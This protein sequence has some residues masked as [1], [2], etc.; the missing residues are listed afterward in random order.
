[1]MCPTHSTALSDTALLHAIS[2]QER[3]G[4]PGGGK[5]IL[6]QDEHTGALSTLNNQYVLSYSDDVER[7]SRRS[8]GGGDISF[9]IIGNHDNRPTDMTN[10]VVTDD[11][12][13]CTD[14]PGGGD[15]WHGTQTRY[16][17]R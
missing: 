5:G 16:A 2:F 4:K 17:E 9:S 3:A 7:E 1:M 12:K 13:D 6:I 10:L 14:G 15:T 8:D 11:D